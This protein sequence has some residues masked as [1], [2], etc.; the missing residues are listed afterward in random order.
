MC[1]AIWIGFSVTK[2]R[3]KELSDRPRHTQKKKRPPS[4]KVPLLKDGLVIH[5]PRNTDHRCNGGMEIVRSVDL[6]LHRSDATFACFH[7][8]F[9]GLFIAIF[10]DREAFRA[11]HALFWAPLGNP[12]KI[13]W[14]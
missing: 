7:S 5:I 11:A 1:A 9:V 2:I 10:L 6:G 8:Q 3:Y 4:L 14:L 12:V 13:G